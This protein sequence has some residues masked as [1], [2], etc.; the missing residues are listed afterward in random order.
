MGNAYD[1]YYQNCDTA[2]PHAAHNWNGFDHWCGGLAGITGTDDEAID[3]AAQRK[4][5]GQAN[6]HPHEWYNTL[7]QKLGHPGYLTL[8]E[9]RAAEA[10]QPTQEANELR[11][12]T[13][14]QVSKAINRGAD[15]VHQEFGDDYADLINLVANAIGEALDNP[16]TTLDEAIENNYSTDPA[17]VR[18]WI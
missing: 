15:L 3:M 12:F 14:E 16:G 1:E 11:L 5:P 17:I 10:T 18:G 4:L 2:E 6:A 8:A 13:R 7:A 9:I